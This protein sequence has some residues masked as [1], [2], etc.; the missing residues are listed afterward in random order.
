M[1]H[2]FD[3]DYWEEHWEQVGHSTAAAGEAGAANPHL[4]R[5]VA[6]LAPGTALD[7]GCGTGAEAIWLAGHGWQ[8]TAADISATVLARAAALADRASVTDAVTWVE[9]DL[10]AWEPG[11]Q[12]D[13]VVTNYAH[14]AIPQLAFYDRIA[15][16]V[17]P[18]GTLLIVGHLQ[19]GAGPAHGHEDGHAPGDQHQHQ[20]QHQHGEHSQQHA[21][22]PDVGDEPPAEATVTLADITGRLDPQV[23]RIHTAEEQS[24][25]RPGGQGLPLHD[26]IVR[27]SRLR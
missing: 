11:G 18:G 3:K 1:T 9:A 2:N 27:A 22:T 25:E 8:V 12:F 10:T 17:A 14:P 24:R 20:H 21:S 23:W 19:H 7:A 16:W 6:A 4:I 26:V 15:R 5:E 13:L